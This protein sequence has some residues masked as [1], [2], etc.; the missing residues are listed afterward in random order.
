[1]SIQV[2]ELRR[3]AQRLVHAFAT[4][5]RASDAREVLGVSGT[6]REG[7]ALHLRREIANTC[8]SGGKAW[9]VM[10]AR[11]P[12]AL[13]GARPDSLTADSVMIWMLA[14][15]A[16]ERRPISFARWSRHCLGLVCRA[17]PQAAMFYNYVPSPSRSM[18]WLSWL[19]AWFSATERF[20]SPWTGELFVRFAIDPEGV[21][22]ATQ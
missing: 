8:A 17:F 2:I 22:C 14:T 6:S 15:R 11:T 20:I 12:L 3:P 13:F 5:L 9:M 16:T 18:S 21:L 10:D 7:L 19:G 4:D 1:M